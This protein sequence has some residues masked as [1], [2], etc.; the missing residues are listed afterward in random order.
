[1]A[2]SDYVPNNDDQFAAQ[3]QNFKTNLGGYAAT[4]G[5]SAAQLTA[6][7]ADADSF[8]YV[9]ASQEIMQNGAQQWT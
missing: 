3:L 5:V 7:A 6:Q 4:L 8:T 1:M 9:L 2:K